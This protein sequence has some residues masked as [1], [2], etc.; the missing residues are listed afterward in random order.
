MRHLI[1]LPGNSV[2]NLAWGELM[3]NHY[4]PFFDS[5]FLQSYRHWESR[6][7]NLD[8]VV[9]EAKL[10]E[11]IANLDLDTEVTI[12]A[13]SAGSLLALLAIN[14]KSLL[15]ERCVF[16]GMPLDLAAESL[17]KTDWSPLEILK[18]PSLAFHN[19]GDPTTSYEFTR[20]LLAEKAP[21]IEFITTY[22]SDHWYGDIDTYDIH[23]NR[24]I[25]MTNLN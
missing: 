10:K 6:K 4:Q 7:D 21:G 2:K 8:F 16:F 1:I 13:K 22:E 17:F 15:P 5:A 12:M 14:N 20:R 11:H 19:V 3:L 23:C 9:E 18:V 25:T 24:L